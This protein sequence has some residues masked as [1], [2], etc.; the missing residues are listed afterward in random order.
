MAT[1]DFSDKVVIVK[2]DDGSVGILYPVHDC[3]LSLEQI[4]TK[5]IPAGTPHQI[6]NGTEVPSD[7]TYFNAWTYV[8]E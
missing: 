2:Q 4:I 8:E 3:G 7:H 6:V 1:Y 5:D